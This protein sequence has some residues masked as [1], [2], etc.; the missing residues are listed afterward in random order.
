MA[1][2]RS[3]LESTEGNKVGIVEGSALGNVDVASDGA[4]DGIADRSVL[5][6][7]VGFNVAL[8]DG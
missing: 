3:D 8:K 2:F 1:H 7:D 6:I 4:S 5:G